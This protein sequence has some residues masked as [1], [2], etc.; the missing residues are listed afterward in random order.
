MR[1]KLTPKEIK[2]YKS[3]QISRLVVA[4]KKAKDSGGKP[5]IFHFLTTLKC[6]CNCESC[7]WKDNSVKNEYMRRAQIERLRKYNYPDI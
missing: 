1:K 3:R 7:F 6:N 4:A 5:F 2:Q